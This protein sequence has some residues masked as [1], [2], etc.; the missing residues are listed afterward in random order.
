MN[1]GT[2]AIWAI[3][4]PLPDVGRIATGMSRARE[5]INISP[6]YSAFMETSAISS[7]SDIN[8]MLEP[9]S[10]TGQPARPKRIC[11]GVPG[12]DRLVQG[13]FLE[14]R[15]YTVCGPPGSGKTTFCMQFLIQGAS[16]G[17]PGLYVTFYENP[18]S[19]YLDMSNY[20]FR[21]PELLDKGL[22]KFLDMSQASRFGWVTQDDEMPSPGNVITVLQ[23][24]VKEHAISRLV[25]D[26]LK[27]IKFG[28]SRPDEA[29]RDMTD[30]MHSLRDL[31][32]TTLAISE[33]EDP[34]RYELEQHLS[35]GLIF[36]HNFLDKGR[37]SRS[38]QVMK[39][40]GTKHDCEMRRITFG[41]K[42]IQ[43][44]ASEEA[45]G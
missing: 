29:R 13:G 35:H 4:R 44:D 45:M 25:I 31:G 28:Y 2:L 7:S 21:L 27:A 14:K 43:I 40:R 22:I 30:F 16:E 37:M 24:L 8:I 38:I 19:I 32:C 17:F 41:P 5:D 34:D 23:R 15:I 33:L 20:A 11:S 6:R 18:E 3:R 1:E 42:G 12:L 36:L 26:S 9:W 10:P 39:M